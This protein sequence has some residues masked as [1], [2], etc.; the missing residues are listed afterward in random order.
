[1]LAVAA[2]L[3]VLQGFLLVTTR[4]VGL[5]TLLAP[6]LVVNVGLVILV[7]YR[8]KAVLRWEDRGG[9]HAAD[10]VAYP[11]KKLELL[12]ATADSLTGRRSVL[13][14]ES[15]TYTPAFSPKRSRG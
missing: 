14:Q 12:V 11:K 5:F 4:R 2:L 9:Q 1:M 8:R 15:P 6:I 10:L 3:F 13:N 7:F